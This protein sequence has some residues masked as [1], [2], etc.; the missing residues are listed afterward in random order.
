MAQCLETRSKRISG[1][2]GVNGERQFRL[3]LGGDAL[4]MSAE[5][6]GT[7]YDLPRVGE[8]CSPG[9]AE[10]WRSATAVEEFHAERGLQHLQR[11]AHRRLNPP[12]PASSGR[13]AAGL[14]YGNKDAQ[15]I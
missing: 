7:P 9:I 12:K 4:G 10:H 5:A 2:N 3:D 1:Q 8:Q 11:L 15:L 6:F 13:K 14:G